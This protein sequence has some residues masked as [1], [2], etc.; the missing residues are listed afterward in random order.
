MINLLPYKEKRSIEK[1]RFARMLQ[2]VL[3]AL[4]LLIIISFALI[5]PT[6]ITISS[7]H[8]LIAKQIDSLENDG[9]ITSSVDLDSLQKRVTNLQ[10]KLNLTVGPSPV[11]RITL[12][13]TLAPQ[14]ITVER[15]AI[16]GSQTL[17]VSGVSA[18]REILQLF[19]SNLSAEKS[20]ATVDNPVSNFIKNKNGTFKLTVGFK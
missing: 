20:I 7:R 9:K 15:F 1:I 19:I 12:V 3:M 16:S 2:T 11:E 4:L 8:N 18:N 17:E 6:W 14:G 5:A 10:N 13:R